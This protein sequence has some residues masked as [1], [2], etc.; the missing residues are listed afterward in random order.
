[1]K[2]NLINY[3]RIVQSIILL[4]LSGRH[5]GRLSVVKTWRRSSLGL[6][7]PRRTTDVA[8]SQTAACCPND[9]ISLLV[10]AML[11][12]IVVLLFAQILTLRVVAATYLHFFCL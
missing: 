10:R 4:S 3:C 11:K 6:T 1:M 2:L 12:F 5:L 7:L 8:S 9:R